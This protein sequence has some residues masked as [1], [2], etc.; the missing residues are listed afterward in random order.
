MQKKQISFILAI[1]FAVVLSS[2]CHREKQFIYD[3]NVILNRGMENSIIYFE[4]SIDSNKI[5]SS[6]KDID[7]M[8][9]SI[10]SILEEYKEDLYLIDGSKKQCLSDLESPFDTKECYN[11]LFGQDKKISFLE[12]K[13][14][15][16][17]NCLVAT[18]AGYEQ[19]DFIVS[20]LGIIPE[21]TKKWGEKSWSEWNFELLPMISVIANLDMIKLRVCTVHYAMLQESGKE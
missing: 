11:Y 2:S 20:T 14:E 5:V 12:C 21:K 10:V 15:D 16:Y 17:Q 19:K 4:K 1:L 9:R 7:S 8:F 18:V 3:A 6:F 13:I